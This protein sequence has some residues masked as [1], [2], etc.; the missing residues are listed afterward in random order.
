MG[1]DLVATLPEASDSAL[2]VTRI[3]PFDSVFPSSIQ[4][5][6]GSVVTPA[7]D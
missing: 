4:A 5:D 2:L 1:S 3:A 6:V 7:G